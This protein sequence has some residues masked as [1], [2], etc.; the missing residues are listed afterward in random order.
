[1]REA[2]RGLCSVIPSANAGQ[3]GELRPIVMTK[4]EFSQTVSRG[5]NRLTNHPN[6]S[7]TNRRAGGTIDY[8]SSDFSYRGSERRVRRRWAATADKG[9]DHRQRQF[10][11]GHVEP[12][13]L[14]N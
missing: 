6:L 8:H 11:I 5:P 10:G 13:G 1:M 3:D 2:H 9:D 14:S 12:A 4:T 7:A